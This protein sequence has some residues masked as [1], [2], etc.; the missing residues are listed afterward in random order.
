MSRD[1]KKDKLRRIID[2]IAGNEKPGAGEKKQPKV[3]QTIKGGSNNTQ[4]SGN[5]NS[6]RKG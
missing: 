5:N 2:E 4:I 6:V 1:E 3:S